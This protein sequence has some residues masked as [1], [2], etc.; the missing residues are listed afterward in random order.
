ML[1]GLNDLLTDFINFLIL[2]VGTTLDLILSLFPS[3]PFSR[4]VAPPSSV[5]LGWITWLVPFPTMMLHATL[6]GSTILIYYSIRVLAR[7]VKMVRS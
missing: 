4:P 5:N 1:D 2:G 3:T 6:L 7:W